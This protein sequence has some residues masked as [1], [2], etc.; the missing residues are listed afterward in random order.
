MFSQLA[1]AIA[2]PLI[3]WG[4]ICALLTGVV[5][6]HLYT[7]R[8]LQ[9]QLVTAQLAAAQKETELTQVRADLQTMT[10]AYNAAQLAIQE[11]R[12]NVDMITAELKAVRDTDKAASARIKTIHAKLANAR[13]QAREKE[14]RESS[15]AD[16][17]LWT[18]NADI[19]CKISNFARNGGECVAGKWVSK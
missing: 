6:Y 7:K 17:L 1:T 12:N 9:A 15:Q 18:Y 13:N 14:L 10:A 3:K 8:S 16:L 5:G 2:S 19:A 11:A 4:L